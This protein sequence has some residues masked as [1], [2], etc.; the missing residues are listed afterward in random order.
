MKT[1][2]RPLCLSKDFSTVLFLL[3]LFI[4]TLPVVGNAPGDQTA[5]SNDVNSWSLISVEENELWSL[6]LGVSENSARFQRGRFGELDVLE[7]E[8]FRLKL[9]DATGRVNEFSSESKWET[10]RFQRI[11]D[12][13]ELVFSN[14]E[15]IE[16][17]SLKISGQVDRLGISWRVEVVNK[18]PDYSVIEA[19]YPFPRIRGNLLNLFVPDRPGRALLDVGR[20]GFRETYEYPGHIASMQYF[21]YWGRESGIYLGVHDPFASMKTFYVDA[22]EGTSG[23]TAVFP[24]IGAGLP[25]NSFALAGEV[26]WEALKG[27]WYDKEFV[28][29]KATW[30]PPKGRPDTPKQFKKIPYWICD[31]IPN[32]PQQGDARPMTLGAASEKYEKN[33]WIDAA[34]RLKERLGVPIAYQVYNWH[35]IPFNINYPH[36]LPAKKEFTDGA[37]KLKEAGIYIFPYINAVSWEMDD[38]DEGFELNFTNVGSRGAAL[39]PD[40]SPYFFPYPQLKK[41]GEKTRLAPICPGFERWGQIVEEIARGIETSEPIDGIYFDQV[42]AVAPLPCRSREHGHLPGGGSYWSDG[43][44]RAMQRI[45]A[46]RPSDSFYYS[47]SN[48]EPYANSFDGF[49]TWIWT[50]GDQVPAFPAIYAGRIQMLGRYTDGATRDDDDYFRYHLAEELVYGQQLGW[51]NAEIVYK[52]ERLAFLE[53]LV[54]TRVQWTNMFNEGKLLRPPVVESD[55]APVAS[56][57]ITMRQVIA[58]VWKTD[59]ASKIALFVVN[60]S[61]RPARATIGLFPKEYGIDGPEELKLDLNPLDVQVFELQ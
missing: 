44:N 31:Y 46:N 42:S 25:S 1:I 13:L 43:Y 60:I 56:S 27:D 12:T 8:I 52:E 23:I 38:A 24:A 9:E 58:G 61:K 55:L 22:S 17:I 10:V 26:R 15:Q 2:P 57:G 18:S 19:T 59:D 37:S 7:G 28:L 48:A 16:N 20:S 34:V 6:T 49:L 21:A 5:L 53:K 30:L 47:E 36:F 3:F 29:A 50:K 41:S 32:S 14:P 39:K 33:Y 11:D 4:R 35:E 54:K 40:G 45:R 51:L